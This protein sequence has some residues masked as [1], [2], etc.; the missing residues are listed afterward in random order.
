MS[1]LF[2]MLITLMLMDGIYLLL[3]FLVGLNKLTNLGWAKPLAG[4]G[5]SYSI[6][7]WW[8][9]ELSS[10]VI[11][12]GTLLFLLGLGLDFRGCSLAFSS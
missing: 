3:Y 7:S 6:V 9:L 2:T 10:H 11:V 4:G 8:M 5:V 1:F 12:C